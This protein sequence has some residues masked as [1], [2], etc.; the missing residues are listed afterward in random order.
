MALGALIIGLLSL[1]ISWVPFIG[2]LSVVGGLIA[3]VLG[4]LGR[5]RAKKVANGAGMALTGIIVGALA[6]VVGI[7]STAVPVLFFQDMARN[8]ED[9]D[10]CIQETG[11][12]DACIQEH[13]PA[14][15]R[16]LDDLDG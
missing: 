6:L 9:V 4:F 13:A 15:L 2:L 10:R 16:N 5:G 1:L 12:E 3:V 11:N 14:W 7:L 8:F